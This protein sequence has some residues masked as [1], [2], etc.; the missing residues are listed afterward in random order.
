LLNFFRI[1][2]PYRL[3]IVL[4]LLIIA[5]LPFF[6]GEY[7]E[8]IPELKWLLTGEKL[9]NG[10]LMYADIWDTTAPLSSVVYWGVYKLFG[11]SYEVLSLLAA[12]IY[13][14]QAAMF[15]IYLLRQRAYNENSYIPALTY[16]FF[17]LIFFDVI[18]LSPQLMG[19]TFIIPAYYYLFNHLEIS[20]KKDQN[21]I[22]IGIFTGIAALFYLPY[23]IYL[24][25]VMLGLLFFTNTILRRYLLMVYGAAFPLIILWMVYFLKGETHVLN[26]FYFRSLLH[27]DYKK[28]LSYT[29]IGAIMA[30]PFLL[31]TLAVLK[32][33]GSHGFINYQVRIQNIFFLFLIFLTAGWF[34]W[35][36]KNGSSL[37]VFI[38]IMAFFFTHYVQL[39]RKTIFIELTF[40]LLLIFYLTVQYLPKR[41]GDLLSYWLK[42]DAM[43]VADESVMPQF[44]GKKLLVLGEEMSYYQNAVLGSPFLNWRISKSY[45]LDTDNYTSLIRIERKLAEDTPEVIYDPKGNMPKLQKRIP[46][47]QRQYSPGSDPNIYYWQAP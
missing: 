18:S 26:E 12:I 23:L 13:F 5:K 15:N 38:P 36:E 43:L 46:W 1:N 28:Y 45:I 16:V 24:P 20:R 9:S 30:I 25:S 31:T 33:F 40:S 29:H 32:T 10:H 11:R 4:V 44:K 14:L 6:F 27:L 2:D 34:L 3:L 7:P 41:E 21:L 19:L 17:G 47:L 35:G 39:V 37:I 42:P 8:T 22:N